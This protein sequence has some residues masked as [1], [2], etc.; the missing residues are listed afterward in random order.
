MTPKNW[1]KSSILSCAALAVV[2]SIMMLAAEVTAA[3][4]VTFSVSAA[5]VYVSYIYIK[6]SGVI[7]AMDKDFEKRFK[8]ENQ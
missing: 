7:D 1:I 6:R 3:S 2:V 4:V 8:D 5:A